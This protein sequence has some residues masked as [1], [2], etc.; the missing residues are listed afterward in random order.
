MCSAVTASAFQCVD[1]HFAGCRI[2]VGVGV[3]AGHRRVVPA[4]CLHKSHSLAGES[5]VAYLT[6][7]LTDLLHTQRDPLALCLLL[8]AYDKW[9]PPVPPCCHQ[10]AW[11]HRY[12]SRWIPEPAREALVSCGITAPPEARP[13]PR[14]PRG[15]FRGPRWLCLSCVALRLLGFQGETCYLLLSLHQRRSS[16][17]SLLPTCWVG[18]RMARCCREWNLLLASWL[19]RHRAGFGAGGRLPFLFSLP[20]D[21]ACQGPSFHQWALA[22]PSATQAQLSALAAPSSLHSV[23]TGKVETRNFLYVGTTFLCRSGPAA[24][25]LRMLGDRGT[26]NGGVHFTFN[27]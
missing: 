10:L 7:V 20:S 16:V 3:I 23:E 24:D 6:A 25:C 26:I 21:L 2:H 5:V 19:P 14:K 12:Y 9:E 15:V 1:L 13:Q 17:A 4:G 27:F 22:R 11:F 18:G 8:Q